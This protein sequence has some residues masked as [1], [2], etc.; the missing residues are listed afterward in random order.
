MVVFEHLNVYWV[1]N[2]DSNN[3]TL[4]LC[5]YPAEWVIIP[6]YFEQQNLEMLRGNIDFTSTFFK[7]YMISFLMMSK[8]ID[9]DLAVL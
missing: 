2:I 7:A 1:I 6:T 5:V 3:L 4:L 9:F 8:L